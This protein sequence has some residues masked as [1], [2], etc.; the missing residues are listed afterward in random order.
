MADKNSFGQDKFWL[1]YDDEKA[2]EDQ[3]KK[4]WSPCDDLQASEDAQKNLY[5]NLIT[6]KRVKTKKRSSPRLGKDFALLILKA[7]SQFP[8]KRKWRFEF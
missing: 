4:S 5:R 2:I 8:L 6:K 3:K 1:G 7:N